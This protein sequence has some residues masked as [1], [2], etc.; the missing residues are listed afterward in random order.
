M[1]NKSSQEKKGKKY[2]KGR[3][4]ICRAQNNDWVGLYQK[5]SRKIEKTEGKIH[6]Y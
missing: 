2:G 6:K 5:Q 4:L 3:K 1:G